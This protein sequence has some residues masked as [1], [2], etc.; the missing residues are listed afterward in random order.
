MKNTLHN[1]Y[2]ENFLDNVWVEQGLSKNTLVS[3]EH[4]IK[5]FLIFLQDSK[6]QLL[7]TGYFYSSD[8]K[9]LK[10]FSLCCLYH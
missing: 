5:S 4:D 3:Y 10:L 8:L 9:R 6:I 1:D 2:L 7:Y